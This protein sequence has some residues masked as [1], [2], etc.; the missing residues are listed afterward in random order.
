MSSYEKCSIA[1]AINRITH[2]ELVLPAIQRS[3]VWSGSKITALFDSIFRGYPFG[4]LLFWNTREAIQY[5]DFIRDW[6]DDLRYTLKQKAAGSRSTMVL[7]GQQ[8][9]QSLYLGLHGTHRGR[10]LHLDLLSGLPG[11][12][13]SEPRYGFAFL[14][15][16]DAVAQN[17]ASPGKALWVR[18]SELAALSSQTE[19]MMRSQHWL[20]QVNLSPFST[21]GMRLSTNIS[22][23]FSKFR[24]EELLSYFT[25]DKNYGDDG[26]VT[27]L[28]EVLEIFV[29]I[30][31]GGQVL[32][33]SDLMMSLIQSQWDHAYDRL[34]DLRESLNQ[35]GRFSFDKDFILKCA[36]VCLDR[37]ARYD[38][39]KL[40]DAATMTALQQQFDAIHDA[41]LATADWL[42][43]EAKIKDDRVLGSY[44]ALIPFVWFFFQQP[45]QKVKVEQTRSE[46]VQ[47]LYLALMSRCFTRYSDGR[48]DAFLRDV[49]RPAHATHP[50]TFPLKQLQNFSWDKEGYRKLNDDL[51]QRN[52]T[53]VMNILEGGAQLPEGRRRYPPELDH[54]FPQSRLPAHGYTDAQINHYANFRLISKQANNWKRAEDPEPYFQTNPAVVSKYFIPADLLKYSQF[55][56]FLE[57]RRRLIWE[58]IRDVLGLPVS[59]L[60]SDL[61]PSA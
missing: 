5:R 51:L 21:D 24:G 58:R 59:A 9:L 33:K 57:A 30:N 37:G 7:D 18:V 17:A 11:D 44:N 60:P 46:L 43:N 16:Q 41:L 34:E 25:I 26:I 6:S 35:R 45:G 1:T 14:T 31:S 12:D 22:I 10:R 23:A 27:S 15:D 4:T 49:L 54:I 38:V 2:D 56:K 32:S 55:P 36:L 39:N 42:V 3:F 8:R 20:Q 61:R 48:I 19:V 50:G 47:G 13:I 52:L 40:R 53:L 28:E 29:R